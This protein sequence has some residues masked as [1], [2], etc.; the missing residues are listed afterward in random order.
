MKPIVIK[1]KSSFLREAIFNEAKKL[2]TIIFRNGSR[3]NY[4]DVTKQKFGRFKNAKS[5]SSYFAS[6]IKIKHAVR[7]LKPIV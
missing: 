1:L 2:L 5:K 3:Y 6:N 4:A 7:K